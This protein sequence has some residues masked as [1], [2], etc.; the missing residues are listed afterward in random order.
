MGIPRSWHDIALELSKEKDPVRMRDLSLELEQA[1]NSIGKKL[2][3]AKIRLI[4]GFPD[5]D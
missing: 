5:S 1:L 4:Y 3:A 2:S